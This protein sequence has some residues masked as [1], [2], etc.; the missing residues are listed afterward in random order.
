MN[1]PEM[2]EGDGEFLVDQFARDVPRGDFE[3]WLSEWRGQVDER[4]FESNVVEV[5][6][7]FR[8][9]WVEIAD[10]LSRGQAVR[11]DSIDAAIAALGRTPSSGD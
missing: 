3:R 9:D 8:D 2:P 11:M 7:N 5:T 4:T 1:D 6:V 10:V